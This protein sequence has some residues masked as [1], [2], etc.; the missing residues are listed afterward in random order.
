MDIDVL[1]RIKEIEEQLDQI[2][3]RLRELEDADAVDEL[4]IYEDEY[5]SDGRKS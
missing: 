5:Y 1:E 4:H 2:R 3:V